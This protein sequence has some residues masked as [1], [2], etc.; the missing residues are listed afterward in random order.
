[1][2]LKTDT[3]HIHDQP[4]IRNSTNSGSTVH[5]TQTASNMH[6]RH[7]LFSQNETHP[8][9]DEAIQGSNKKC[10]LTYHKLKKVIC[11]RKKYIGMLP[12][13]QKLTYHN[14]KKIVRAEH[15]HIFSLPA[16]HKHHMSN[17]K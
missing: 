10:R 7:M 12:S 6:K 5:A 8:S 15:N 2:S 16:E 4:L 9:C 1:M 14:L 3:P 11:E 13:R 17:E